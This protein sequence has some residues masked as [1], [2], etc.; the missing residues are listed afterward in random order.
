MSDLK[1]A[2]KSKDAFTST[3]LRSVLAE[4]QAL[5]KSSK[6]P[7]QSNAIIGI[8][9]KALHRRHEAATKYVSASRP[10]LAE[11]ETREAALLEAYVPPLLPESEI[12]RVLGEVAAEETEPLPVD[13]KAK[14]R[15]E[16]RLLKAFYTRVDKALVDPAVVK[17]CVDR[18]LTREASG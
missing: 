13:G 12:S 11:T 14:G 18:L 3:T 5:D 7:A 17:R 8:L 4:I 9:R 16:G 1:T 15:A 6:S 10:D 2:M